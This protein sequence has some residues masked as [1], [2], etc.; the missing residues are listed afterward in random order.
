MVI[1][2]P[3]Q[4]REQQSP[5]PRRPALGALEI[6]TDRYLRAAVVALV[7][8]ILV[9]VALEWDRAHCLQ[10]S[11]SAYYYTPARSVFVAALVAIGVALVAI[12]GRSDGEDVLLNL[13]GML[14][15][16]VAFVPTPVV[17][18]R[19]DACWTAL[20]DSP[21]YSPIP[22]EA[23]DLSIAN[24]I[25]SLLIVGFFVLAATTVGLL[26]KRARRNTVS[27]P[28]R[29]S[30]TWTAGLIAADAMWV[31]FLLWYWQDPSWFAF[32][33][34]AHYVAAISLFGL[35]GWVVL[36]NA[37][38]VRER[39]NALDRKDE[40][41]AGTSAP[42]PTTLKPR[43]A[44]EVIAALM[45]L[46]L[47]LIGA[48]VILGKANVIDSFQDW[49]LWLELAEIACFTSFW[50]YQTYL[51]LKGRPDLTPAPSAN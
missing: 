22:H 49:V 43:S 28:S 45:V 6:K 27:P 12:R 48:V 44:Y 10:T 31:L 32:G 25:A 51:L 3:T 8:L 21:W 29:W 40:D 47:V 23:A 36:I 5:P 30:G 20:I 24:N 1:A 11:I 37:K 41:R 18:D 2:D 9:A 7:A 4:A 38:R 13:A 50:I 16:I 39:D 46:F 35:I 17:D 15:P 34:N 19:G 26:L 33:T 42:R 14:A